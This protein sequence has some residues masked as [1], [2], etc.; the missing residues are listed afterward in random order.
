MIDYFLFHWSRYFLIT[1]RKHT[2][3]RTQNIDLDVLFY[4]WSQSQFLNDILNIIRKLQ[5]KSPDV[6]T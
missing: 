1:L 3:L 5:W 6:S 2:N 4:A